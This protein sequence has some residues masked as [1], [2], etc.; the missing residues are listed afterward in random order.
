MIPV[1]DL[2]D[3]NVVEKFKETYTTIGFAVLTNHFTKDEQQLYNSWFKIIKEFFDLDLEIKNQYE[4][5]INVMCGYGSLASPINGL[6]LSETFNFGRGRIP[7]HF[8]PKEILNFKETALE[9][10]SIADSLN[11]KV[12]SIF[13][14]VIG[15]P[16]K[17]LTNAHKENYTTTRLIHYPI[18]DG[19]LRDGQ[20]RMGEHNDYGTLT[21]LW[22]LEDVPGLEVKDLDGN[23][24]PVPYIEN[25]VV[26]NIADLLQ[27]WTN[28]FLK[29]TRHRVLKSHLHIP[30]YSLT[31]FIDPAPN[32]R[33]ENLMKTPPIYPVIEAL[34]VT[35]LFADR[36]SKDASVFDYR[37]RIKDENGYWL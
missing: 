21:F 5:D 6:D 2:N 11:L 26:C 31:H 29:S 15:R 37:G 28:D 30:R 22:Q 13:D 36:L 14:E 10:T 23:W 35:D 33:I 7:L 18:Y 27:R 20:E 8:W 24:H 34:D 17:P 12:L 19:E 25:G 32:T 3:K 1:I 9:A 16:D 4:F